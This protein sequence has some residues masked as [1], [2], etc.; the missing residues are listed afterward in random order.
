[1]ESVMPV[2]TA[3]K[4]GIDVDGLTSVWNSPSTSPPRTLTA[5]TSVIMEPPWADP[6][7]VSRSTTQ[8]VTARKE[9]PSSSKL[10]CDS[11][12]GRAPFA[13]KGSNV[14]ELMNATLDAATDVFGDPTRNTLGVRPGSTRAARVRRRRAYVHA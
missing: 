14:V 10:R 13:A 1:M 2:S 4:A 7:V 5:P 8:K 12:R 3:M 11:Q 9:R 6:P